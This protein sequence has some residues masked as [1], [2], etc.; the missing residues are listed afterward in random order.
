MLQKS[1]C[2]TF[3]IAGT[4]FYI[5]SCFVYCTIINHYLK[6]KEKLREQKHEYKSFLINVAS[7]KESHDETA[8]AQ[9]YIE[10]TDNGCA[11]EEVF[12]ESFLIILEVAFFMT[13][14]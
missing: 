8:H 6:Q 4:K 13:N 14:F 5:C 1:F 2:K 3:F 11:F 7:V 10:G 9:V 12:R